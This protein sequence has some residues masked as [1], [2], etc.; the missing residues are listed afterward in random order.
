MKKV[1]A[2]AVGA[3]FA[4]ASLGSFAGTTTVAPQGKTQQVAVQKSKSK[5]GV[6]QVKAKKKKHTRHAKKTPRN[7]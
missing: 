5:Q 6:Q 1:I 4:L 3:V 7:V 2:T